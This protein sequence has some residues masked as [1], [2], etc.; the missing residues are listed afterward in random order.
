MLRSERIVAGIE[1]ARRIFTNEKI[2]SI[3]GE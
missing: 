1:R 2:E 3:F